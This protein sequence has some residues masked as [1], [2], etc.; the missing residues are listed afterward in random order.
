MD[1]GGFKPLTLSIELAIGW[2]A[3]PLSLY[4]AQSLMVLF[5]HAILLSADKSKIQ[6]QIGHHDLIHNP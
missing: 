4:A 6:I 5:P 1:A 2:H 3:N